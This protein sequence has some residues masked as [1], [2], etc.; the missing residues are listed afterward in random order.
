MYNV[1]PLSAG[2]QKPKPRVKKKQENKSLVS[3]IKNARFV[4]AIAKEVLYQVLFVSLPNPRDPIV[5]PL[6]KI[7][8]FSSRIKVESRQ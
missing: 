7:L 1:I 5:A 6:T 2:R 3:S 4:V 8:I